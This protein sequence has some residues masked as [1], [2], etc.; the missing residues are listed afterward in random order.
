MH[1]Q[2]MQMIACYT[3][4][5]AV[6]TMPHPS[7]DESWTLVAGGHTHYTQALPAPAAVLRSLPHRT[8]RP[9]AV[10][11]GC[12]DG[13]LV[14]LDARTCAALWSVDTSTTVQMGHTLS[15]SKP[16][17]TPS[18]QSLLQFKASTLHSLPFWTALCETQT[19]A[20]QTAAQPQRW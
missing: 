7:D 16:S 13:S 3:T 17:R 14:G 8:G 11:A 9:S 18:S 20:P 10:L 5:P 15:P 12:E 6:A 19:A 2:C 1:G 4:N